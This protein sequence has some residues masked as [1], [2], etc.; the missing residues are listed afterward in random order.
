MID[1]IIINVPRSKARMLSGERWDLI[2]K[3]D[4]YSKFARNPTKRPIVPVAA[5]EKNKSIYYPSILKKER[6][7]KFTPPSN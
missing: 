4:F 6:L 3:K 7:R 5:T 2:A 1:T